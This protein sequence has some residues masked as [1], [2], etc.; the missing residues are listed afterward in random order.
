M[1]PA[2]PEEK[3]ESLISKPKKD[4]K[5]KRS[6]KLEDPQNKAGPARRRRKNVIINVDIDSVHQFMDD[7]ND[8]VED[9]TLDFTKFKAELRQCEAELNRSL[10]EWKALRLLCDQKE[11]EIKDLREELTRAQE[12]EDEL[13]KQVTNVLKEYGLP[14]PTMKANTSMSQLQQKVEMLEQLRG[15]VGRVNA[16]C[17]QWKEKMDLLAA[18]K[19]AAQTKLAAAEAQLRSVRERSSAQAKKIAELEAKLAKDEA[20]VAEARVEAKKTQITA[21]KTVVVYL[22][23]TEAAQMELREAVDQEK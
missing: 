22:R 23:D 13:E 1:R 4:N 11:E 7:E 14:L 21:D 17:N 2:P 6:S 20:E 19:E 16:E 5:R 15:E 12:Y 3:I 8:E 18:G 10:G 9:S